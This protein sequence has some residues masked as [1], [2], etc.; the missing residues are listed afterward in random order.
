MTK[1]ILIHLKAGRETTIC[2]RGQSQPAFISADVNKVT[3][4]RCLRAEIAALRRAEA[5]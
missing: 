4:P 5:R 1:R 3:C 2:G